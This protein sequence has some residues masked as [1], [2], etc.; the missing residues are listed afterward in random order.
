MRIYE[1]DTMKHS[2]PDG[3]CKHC[4]GLIRVSN[5]TDDNCRS[6]ERTV[7]CLYC[8]KELEIFQNLEIKII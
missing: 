3:A 4:K 6:I 2:Y 1:Y 5:D 7:E 8:G